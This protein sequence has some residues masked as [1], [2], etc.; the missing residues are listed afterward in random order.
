MAKWLKTMSQ[1]HEM[2]VP[3]GQVA[4]TTMSQGHE[5]KVPDGQVAKDNDVSGT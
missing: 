3:D 4:K 2:E 5:M 1:G